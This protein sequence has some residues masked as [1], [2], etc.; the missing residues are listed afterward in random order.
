M[1]TL[2][3]LLDTYYETSDLL[4]NYRDEHIRVLTWYRDI[5]TDDIGESINAVGNQ[6]RERIKELFNILI[7]HFEGKK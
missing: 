5:V 2:K 1:T 6:A 3:E 7:E 4:D